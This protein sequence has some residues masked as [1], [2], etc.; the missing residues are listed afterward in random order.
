MLN[1][2]FEILETVKLFT[3]IFKAGGGLG[4]FMV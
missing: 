2:N 3:G 4:Q 1:K